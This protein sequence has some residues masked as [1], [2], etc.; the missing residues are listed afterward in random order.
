MTRGWRAY[1]ASRDPTKVKTG[2]GIY[3]EISRGLGGGW[4]P[5]PNASQKSP[6]RR[7]RCPSPKWKTPNQTQ[8]G[9]HSF[10]SNFIHFQPGVRGA[11]SIRV[12]PIIIRYILSFF[13]NTR[14]VH[15]QGTGNKL[16]RFDENS[17]F[18]NFMV[19]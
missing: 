18:H 19:Y 15:V 10:L 2:Y 5:H 14:V 9:R 1:R 12:T 8:I 11:H 7:N 3:I 4:G 16:N 13:V 6:Q 17:C